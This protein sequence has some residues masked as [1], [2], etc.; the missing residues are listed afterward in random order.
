MRNS[1]TSQTS[2]K[3]EDIDRTSQADSERNPFEPAKVE[4]KNNSQPKSNDERAP[5]PEKKAMLF[6]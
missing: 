2:V 5:K 3:A 1:V 6:S 4:I